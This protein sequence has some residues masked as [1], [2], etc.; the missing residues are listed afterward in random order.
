MLD[1]IS[2]ACLHPIDYSGV[3]KIT[4]LS[5][6]ERVQEH[7]NIYSFTFTA[8]KLPTWKAGQHAVFALPGQLVKNLRSD[9]RSEKNWRPFSVASAPHEGIIRI[10]TTIPSPSS[11]FKQQ[12]L[13]LSAG[14]KIRMH[15]PFG[16]LYIRPG[17]K[18]IV[19]V[20]G[21]IGITPFRSIFCDLA[22]NKTDVSLTLIYS[23]RN[24]SY[25]YRSELEDYCAKNPNLH[26]I[27]TEGA[28]EV[29]RKL[30]EQVS[31]HGNDASY[32]IS[33]APGMITALRQSLR[34]RDIQSKKIFNDPFKGY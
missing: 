31:I 12:L 5:F 32:F 11:N 4:D 16:E 20:A 6:K 33:G 7:D 24:Q 19:G 17:M 30:L 25:T 14:K 3:F 15:G 34:E 28:E 1:I 8:D 22:L 2:R 23:A 26:I 13:S 27:Y 21:G 9:G 10:G 29:N 18:K